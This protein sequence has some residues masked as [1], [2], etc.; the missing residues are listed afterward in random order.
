MYAVRNAIDH[1]D[2]DADDLQT[3]MEVE[4]RLSQLWMIVFRMLGQ[5]IPFGPPADA[6]GRVRD[7]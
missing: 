1:G 5:F 4:G 2:I 3:M 7:E 6:S